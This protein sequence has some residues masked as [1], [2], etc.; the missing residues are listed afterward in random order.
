MRKLNFVK[1]FWILL[2][3][4][5]VVTSLPT[6]AYAAEE[7]PEQIAGE[8]ELIAEA[9]EYLPDEVVETADLGEIVG[10]ET[11]AE[12]IYTDDTATAEENVEA[13]E[14][15]ESEV[16]IV[17]LTAEDEVFLDDEECE[18]SSV[19]EANLATQKFYAQPEF[20]T[21]SGYSAMEFF[22]VDN[23]QYIGKCYLI[24]NQAA[25]TSNWLLYNYKTETANA[26]FTKTEIA[27]NLLVPSV[28]NATRADDSSTNYI[29]ESKV[30]VMSRADFNGMYCNWRNFSD[31][32]FTRD[33]AGRLVYATY[34]TNGGSSTGGNS[35][36]SGENG[37]S[38]GSSTSSSSY[39]YRYT[40]S[41]NNGNTYRVY[42]TRAVSYNG[43]KHVLS[44]AKS[45]KKKTND[46]QVY[47]YLNGQ[48]LEASA[49]KVK[50]GNNK[51]VNGYKG[52]SKYVP[53]VTIT[54]KNKALKADTKAFKKKRFGFNITPADLTKGKMSYSKIKNKGSNIV[55]KKPVFTDEKNVSMK[56]V[57]KGNPQTDDFISYTANGALYVTGNNN[58]TGTISFNS[59]PGINSSNGNG[60]SGYTGLPVF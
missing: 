47:V 9:D 43:T 23:N 45:G 25:S 30:P 42:V 55:L 50:V 22:V 4:A 11:E 37:S 19:G 58:F 10:G 39:W 57:Q 51:Y 34:D 1:R 40:V 31:I 26:Y 52:N 27:N 16:P 38:S 24:I 46:I 32:P 5:L 3:A 56:M 20:Q 18:L 44:S 53:Y 6:A 33:A 17:P 13:L 35:G 29:D 21:K 54:F 48:Q 41:M 8:A 59:V 2:T 12:E 14:A 7:I 49:F 28:K 60:N 36:S 15:V